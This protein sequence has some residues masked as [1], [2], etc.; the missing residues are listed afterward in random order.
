MEQWSTKVSYAFSE[1]NFRDLDSDGS[2]SVLVVV[3]R[4]GGSQMSGRRGV[5]LERNTLSL[6]T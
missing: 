4:G 3:C 6:E 1:S 2:G 5:R